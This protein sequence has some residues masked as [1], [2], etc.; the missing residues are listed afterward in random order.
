MFQ[1]YYYFY[2]HLFILFA[3]IM[4][5]FNTYFN[6]KQYLTLILRLN[7]IKYKI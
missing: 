5:Y 3:Q 2:V 7:N 1:N 6:T 4:C